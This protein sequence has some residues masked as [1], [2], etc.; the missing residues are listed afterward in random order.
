MMWYCP[1]TY[2]FPL[3]LLRAAAALSSA[4]PDVVVGTG[5]QVAVPC[6]VAAVALVGQ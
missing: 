4:A 3:C 1:W 2:S 6:C 5:G